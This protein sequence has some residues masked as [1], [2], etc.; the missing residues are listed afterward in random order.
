MQAEPKDRVYIFEQ[1]ITPTNTQRYTRRETA[2]FVFE[3]WA[4]LVSDGRWVIAHLI[5]DK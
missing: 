5:T 2:L 4:T 3:R 1:G